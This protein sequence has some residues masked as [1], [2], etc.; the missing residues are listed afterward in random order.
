MTEPVRIS[1]EDFFPTLLAFQRSAFR[2]EIQPR[3]RED[4]ESQHVRDFLADRAALP[5]DVP[6]YAYWFEQIA[7]HR[8]NRHTVQ[9]VRVHATPPNDYQ[10][11]LQWASRWNVE[12]GGEE[13]RYIDP[14]KAQD[15]GLLAEPR[16]DWWLLDGNRLLVMRFDDAGNRIRNE[17]VTE[18]AAIQKAEAWRDLAIHHSALEPQGIAA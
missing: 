15:L 6:Y 8:R 2:A 1:D 4:E 17:L 12:L 13:I 14:R 18:P 16:T 7:A 3:Y 11:Y 9:R 10:R 5:P